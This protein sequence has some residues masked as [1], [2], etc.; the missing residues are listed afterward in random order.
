MAGCGFLR[1]QL[2]PL[3]PPNRNG[4]LSNQVARGMLNRRPGGQSS[5]PGAEKEKT[6][7]LSRVETWRLRETGPSLHACLPT[8]F[9]EGDGIR[10]KPVGADGAHS[11]LPAP[12]SRCVS[13]FLSNAPVTPTSGPLNLYLPPE[14][15]SRD[16]CE[17]VAAS[18]PS[19]LRGDVPCSE[20]ML[21][22]APT[23]GV[24]VK[25]PV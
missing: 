5:T 25:W 24:Q 14:A 10:T 17:A 16:P 15:S 13:S 12:G 23:L 2:P 20:V 11:P 8:P 3:C 19:G 6:Q 18:H 7:R 1:R 21:L 22:K 9:H 4:F